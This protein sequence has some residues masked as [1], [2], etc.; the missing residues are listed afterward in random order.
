MTVKNPHT[1][2]KQQLSK[3]PASIDSSTISSLQPVHSRLLEWLRAWEHKILLIST[4][5]PNHL[6][7]ERYGKWLLDEY[8]PVVSWGSEDLVALWI[9]FS[10]FS[11]HT[12]VRRTAQREDCFPGARKWHLPSEYHKVLNRAQCTTGPSLLLGPS[13]NLL[14]M[15]PTGNQGAHGCVYVSRA[16]EPSDSIR[17]RR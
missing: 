8:M 16:L 6:S 10:F 7:L 1:W 2:F 14:Q 9:C 5:N 3:I 11:R 12:K 17:Q 15:Q 13:N 4:C